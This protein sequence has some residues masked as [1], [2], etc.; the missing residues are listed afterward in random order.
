VLRANRAAPLRWDLEERLTMP[1]G[2]TVSIQWA[3]LDAPAGTPVL[4]LLHTITGSGDGLRRFVAAAR[5]QLGWVVAACNRRGHAGLPLTAPRINTMGS[6]EDL[7]RQVDAI[8]ARRAGAA[9]Y[10]VGVSAGS[11]LLVRYL[12][13][14]RSRSRLRAAVALC[15]AYDIR[16]AFHHAHPAYDRYLTRNM[17]RFFLRNN[18]DVLGG[19]DGFAECAAAATLSAFHDRLHPLAG[20]A[21]REAFYRASNPMEVAGDVTVPVLVIN[22]ADDPVCVER[23]VHRHLADM[24]QLP[25]MTLALTRRGGHCGFFD[26]L[27]TGASWADR[28]TAEY[29][30]TAHRLL[31]EG[32]ASS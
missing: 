2:G 12:G 22:A 24:R 5:A 30:G 9:L 3:G 20:F 31:G 1:D 18:R 29:L 27:R 28:A 6:T 15:P 32:A 26:G 14:A 23:N 25:R 11:G 17:V 10:G 7:H 19:V 4:V 21:S 16:D 13:E 8:E